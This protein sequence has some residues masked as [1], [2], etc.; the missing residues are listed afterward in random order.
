MKQN[1]SRILRA[2]ALRYRHN[3]AIVN[4]ERGRRYTYWDY[5]L[6]INRIAKSAAGHIGNRRRR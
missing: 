6:L 2:V 1:F 3:E 5:H 4:V